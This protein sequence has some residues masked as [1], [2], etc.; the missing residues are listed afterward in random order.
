VNGAGDI[1]FIPFLAAP[2]RAGKEVEPGAFPVYQ[3]VVNEKARMF[4]FWFL[5][6]E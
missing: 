5:F 4:Q 1:N 3:G 6:E 2:A